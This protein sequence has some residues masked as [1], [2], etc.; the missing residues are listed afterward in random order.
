[1]MKVRAK[2]YPKEPYDDYAIDEVLDAFVEADLVYEDKYIQFYGTPE[3][4]QEMIRAVKTVAT[5]DKVKE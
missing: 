2:V 5:V 4:L 1:M 3:R